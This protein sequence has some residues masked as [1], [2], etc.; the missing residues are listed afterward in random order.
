M[1][2][3]NDDID[4]LFRNAADNY[5]L[6]ISGAD[7]DSIAG[8]LGTGNS[9]DAVIPVIPVP[10]PRSN[11]SYRYLLL[12]LLLPVGYYTAKYAGF[13]NSGR[14]QT[15][16]Q[17]VNAAP[18][19]ESK[20]QAGAPAATT[21]DAKPATDVM[22]ATPANSAPVT[23]PANNTA[24][25]TP[26]DNTLAAKQ[27][28]TTAQQ[29]A[30]K[31]MAVTSPAVTKAQDVKSNSIPEDLSL[32]HLAD[33]NKQLA[34]NKAIENVQ[35]GKA[36]QPAPVVNNNNPITLVP[37][38]ANI[39]PAAEAQNSVVNELTKR[40]QETQ[41]TAGAKAEPQKGQEPP[42]SNPVTITKPKR[43]YIGAFVAP[44]YTTVKYQPGSK[45]GFDFGGLVGYQ[46]TKSL[47]VEV[48]VSLDKKYYTTDG[49]YYDVSNLKW[50]QNS[51]KLLS[52]SGYASLT[53][54]PINLKYSFKPG[55]D[56]NFFVSGG[57][58]SYIVHE[59]NYNY[60]FDKGGF[61]YHKDKSTK[62]STSNLFANF[63]ISAG[64]E[65]SLGNLCNFRIEPYYRVPV[66]GIGLGGLP[67]T[68][69]G[70]NIGITKKIR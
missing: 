12:L 70:L 26:A 9:D 34:L 6:K 36:E 8:R 30:V 62:I 48:G 59:E 44:D 42:I 25:N 51:G 19:A 32:K 35:H 69:V 57:L 39:A 2:H 66:K 14:N 22:T 7:W 33:V 10:S 23:T 11:K 63:N 28:A 5:P 67:I 46:L 16:Q 50:L 31:Q 47:A 58:V 24:V 52:L 60:E 53:E 37:N 41:T 20:K 54:F 38:A 18:P 13:T 21:T 65:S 56:G 68:S 3:T 49:K 17:T 55:K 61:I 15:A 1:Q 29:K 64:Y 40:P 27:P 4:E 45:V 43:L